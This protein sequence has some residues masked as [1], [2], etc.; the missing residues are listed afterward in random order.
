MPYDTTLPPCFG[1][2]DFEFAIH[3]SDQCRAFDWL[4]DLRSRQVSW[5][6]AKAQIHDYLQEKGVHTTLIAVQVAR[7][8]EM[9]G[10]WLSGPMEDKE[11]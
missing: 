2:R 7:A 5:I 8:R 10:P 6:E 11:P 4:T 9:L 1:E 3:P